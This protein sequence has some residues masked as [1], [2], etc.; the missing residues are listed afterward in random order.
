MFAVALF[1]IAC[2]AYWAW[3]QKRIKTT[4]PPDFPG[5]WPIVG[6]ALNLIGDS[7]SMYVYLHVVLVK[8]RLL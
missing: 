2:A 8:M 4:E 3:R 1:C 7:C 5:G 6:H